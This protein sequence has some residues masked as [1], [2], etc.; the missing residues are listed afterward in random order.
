MLMGGSVVTSCSLH[1]LL[2]TCGKCP[3]LC[4]RERG[5][6]KQTKFYRHVSKIGL[7]QRNPGIRLI[8]SRR[9]KTLSARHVSDSARIELKPRPQVPD[10]FPVS[11]YLAFWLEVLARID[12]KS[13]TD[14]NSQIYVYI[15]YCVILMLDLSL[16]IITVLLQDPGSQ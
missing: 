4:A 8:H 11:T 16:N 5:Q 15:T 12:L 1:V 7:I 13:K 2:S 3:G 14:E 10:G 6:Q 9:K